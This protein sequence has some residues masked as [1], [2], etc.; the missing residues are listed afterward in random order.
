M[1]PMEEM[2]NRE[3]LGEDE[4]QEDFIDEEVL[5]EEEITKGKFLTIYLNDQVYGVPIHYIEQIIGIN[6][7]IK[8]SSYRQVP[9]LPYYAKGVF[10][11][12]GMVIP[13]IDLHLRLGM[14]EPEYTDQSCVLISK[15][16]EK[17]VGFIVA[18]VDAVIDIPDE[19]ISSVPKTSAGGETDNLMGIA[20]L[21][22]KTTLL[23]D[24]GKLL[25]QD[26]SDQFYF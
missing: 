12:R 19:L 26:F 5:S 4:M 18:G 21:E 1:S 3:Y 13:L 11:L 20:R 15:I 14:M 6:Y 9:D 24:I 22:G 8:A 7:I 17:I 23:M 2:E 25:P 16:N 10:D